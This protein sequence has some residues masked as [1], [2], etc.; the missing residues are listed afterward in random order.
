MP[1][2]YHSES[3]PLSFTF[4]SFNFVSFPKQRLFQ[5]PKIFGAHY[6]FPSTNLFISLSFIPKNTHT[7]RVFPP[8]L[9]FEGLSELGEMEETTA[10]LLSPSFSSYSNGKIAEIAARTVDEF[11]SD[12]FSD[13]FGFDE[14]R[15]SAVERGDGDEEEF[16]FSMAVMESELPSQTSAGDIFRN[17]QIRPVYSVFN[18]DFLLGRFDFP[19]EIGKENSVRDPVSPKVR[20]PLRKLFLE[21]RETTITTS[22]SSSEEADEF[23][24]APSVTYCVWPP[25]AAEAREEGR[26]RKSRSAVC[27]S[28]KW[29]LK[30]FLHMSHSHGSENNNF[31]VSKEN[32]KKSLGTPA[33]GGN[34]EAVAPLPPP[35]NLNG[36]ENLRSC[37]GYGVPIS[38][39]NALRKN[40]ESF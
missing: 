27:N 20:L 37:L 7:E 10:L 33:H 25:K 18:R 2:P 35:C 11:D 24:G 6:K 34:A 30:D 16:E 17:G 29:K 8:F 4:S 23:D 19:N 14:T 12:E 28:K 22:S 39:V 36:G 3:H 32:E 5:F 21:E 9:S 15:S 1:T 13:E 38:E 40:L 26:C 31:V